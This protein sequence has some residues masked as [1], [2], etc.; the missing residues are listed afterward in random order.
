MLGSVGLA[1][2]CRESLEPWSN[3]MRMEGERQSVVHVDGEEA[4]YRKA[5]SLGRVQI[6]HCREGLRA[7]VGKSFEPYKEQWVCILGSHVV[8]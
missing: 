2:F 7:M 4:R 1:G 5:L 8:Q 3:L 6:I